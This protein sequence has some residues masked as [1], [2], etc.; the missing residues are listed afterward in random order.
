MKSWKEVMLHNLNADH[1]KTVRKMVV[2]LALIKEAYEM[3]P[4]NLHQVEGQ[5]TYSTGNI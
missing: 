3:T 4:H 5:I 1:Y 2:F